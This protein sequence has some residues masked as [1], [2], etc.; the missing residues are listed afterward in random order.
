MNALR[1]WVRA[2]L[3]ALLMG[4]LLP[5]AALAA[6][7]RTVYVDDNGVVKAAGKGNCGK[8]NYTTIQAAVN[9]TSARRVVVCKGIYVEQV[10]VERSLTLEGRSGAVIQAPAGEF[11]AIVLF[12][13][14]QTSRMKGFT[15][16][17]AGSATVGA[18]IRTNGF[19]SD[20]IAFGPTQV[21]ISHNH[22]TDIRDTRF[23]RTG[24]IGIFIF[25][26]QADVSDNTVERYGFAGIVAD[27]DDRADTTAQID[28]N[29]IRGQGA[30]G[31]SESQIGIR[32]DEMSA[33]VE[34][35]TISGNYGSGT[36]G[37]GVGILVEFASSS[38]RD[39]TLKQNNT[40]V[41]FGP[42]DG[43]TLR[44]NEI[45]D[46]A[47]NGIELF[48][49]INATIVENESSDNGGNGI[50]LAANTQSNIVK[51]NTARDNG[52]VDI[53]DDSGTPPANTYVD[54]RCD[55]SSPNGLCQ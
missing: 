47:S 24:G 2:L 48:S 23:G 50:Y 6:S 33:D 43:A 5:G 1:Q 29:I 7:G 40:G 22:I 45:R 28:G 44:G 25:Q 42:G 18:G 4:L 14:P 52:G 30:G 12:R 46:S 26:S 3:I 17:G 31:E 35:N 16:T 19:V 10:T 54:N 9:D 20:D 51:G 13:G 27:G 8:P 49:T 34:D 53:F 41:H 39:N 21:T 11:D 55:T 37:E 38:I 15:I 32:L 36:T